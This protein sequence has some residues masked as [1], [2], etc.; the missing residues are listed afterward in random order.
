MTAGPQGHALVREFVSRINAGGDAW[1]LLT[2]D[3]VVTVNGTT[4]LSGRYAGIELIRC[5]LLDTARVVIR[6]VRV[7][8]DTMIGTGATP[9]TGSSTLME[10]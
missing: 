2:A 6:S 8:I 10:R 3:A 5:I 4:P 1:P 7:D 9:R